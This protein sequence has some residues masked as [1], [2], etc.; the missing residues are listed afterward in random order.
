MKRS[1]REIASLV[2][3]EVAGDGDIRISNVNGIKEALEGEIAFL[4][5]PL[6][7][8]LLSET[9]A[10]A[11]ITSRDISFPSKTLIKTDE[12]S[13]AFSKV[14][15]LFREEQKL[16]FS[17]IDKTAQITKEAKIGRDIAI[18]AHVVIERNVSVG[19]NSV[20]YPNVYIGRD[21][22]I[23]KN[24][25]IYPNVTIR[26]NSIIGDNVIV[27]CGTVIGSDGFG[28]VKV[29]EV[30]QKIPQLGVVVIEDNVEIGANVC[31]DRARFGKTIIGK[32]TKIDNLVQIAHNVRIGENCIVVSQVGISGSSK[33]G[34]NVILAGQVGVVGHIEIGDNVVVGA[35][36]GVNKS[37]P[38]GSI[39]LGSPAKSIMEEKRIIASIKKLPE[40]LRTV[41]RLK[42]KVL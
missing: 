12:P 1:V 5:N 24:A 31:I 22:T 23:G 33:L 30:Y 34:K 8:Q 35:Q 28:F 39:V 42:D 21:T 17:G 40:L 6:Y 19:D 3:G 27:H 14:I 38:T 9:A 25:V 41:K 18:G 26:E 37:V 2:G 36:S 13:I 15:A 4:S 20:I 10:S 11:V 29:G 16:S 32:G 7:K